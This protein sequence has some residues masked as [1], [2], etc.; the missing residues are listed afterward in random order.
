MVFN[1][2][3]TRSTLQKG[4]DTRLAFIILYEMLQEYCTGVK[5]FMDVGGAKLTLPSAKA[6]HELQ[7]VNDPS[8][9]DGWIS[10]LEFD[11]FDKA[12]RAKMYELFGELDQ[13]TW[14]AKPKIENLGG[15]GQELGLRQLRIWRVTQAIDLAGV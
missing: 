3:G 12:K 11:G 9:A 1:F 6:K 13:C 7:R 2:H 4:T 14:K 10:N 8:D 5:L 15:L